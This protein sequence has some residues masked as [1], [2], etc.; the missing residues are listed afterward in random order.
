VKSWST[1]CAF[2]KKV[3]QTV[4][5]VDAKGQPAERKLAMIF[6]KITIN[7]TFP[8]SYFDLP[9]AARQVHRRQRGIEPGAGGSGGPAPVV[10]PPNPPPAPG[11]AGH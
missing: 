3:T 11:P 10:T 7:E 1:D 9:L 4:K 6:D 8:E 2:R 5:G